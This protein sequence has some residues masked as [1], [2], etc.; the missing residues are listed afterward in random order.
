MKKTGVRLNC[1]QILNVIEFL[2]GYDWENFSRSFPEST[3]GFRQLVNKLSGKFTPKAYFQRLDNKKNFICFFSELELLSILRM[4]TY[5]VQSS[6]LELTEACNMISQKLS[7]GSF[8]LL[9]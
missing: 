5:S 4:H 3:A 9:N 7:P 2:E 8:K 1:E 6:N